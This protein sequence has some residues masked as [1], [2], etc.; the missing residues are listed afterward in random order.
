MFGTR[1][2]LRYVLRTLRR[3][4]GFTVVAVA[5]L[6]I[7]IGANAS[8][9]GVVRT[10]LL[11]PLPVEQPGQLKL[12][13]WQRDGDFSI[14]QSGST[15]YTDPATGASLRSNFSYPIYRA[16]ADAKAP[17]VELFAFAFV[18]GVSVA[19]G[20]QPAIAAGGAL[21]DG[22]YF[23][24]LRP[25]MEVGRALGP[26]DDGVDA[27]LVAV[28][29]HALW[30]R[31]F[32]G[33]GDVI[34]RSIRVN[35]AT[36]EVVGVTGT[37]FKGLSMGGFFPQTEITL[38]LSA[39]PRVHPRLWSDGSAF[40][41]DDL[42]WLRLMARVPTEEGET[43]AARRFATAM[44]SVPSPLIGTDGHLPELQLLDGSHGAQPLSPDTARLLYFLLGVVGIVL[45][46]ACLN[47]SSLMLARG[48]VRQRE[49]AVR[50][51]LG[52]GRARLVRQMLLE[53][54]VL[55]GLGTAAGLALAVVGRDFLRAL[56]TGSLGAGALGS[57][58]MEVSLDAPVLGLSVALATV[59]TL[60]FGLLPALRLSRVDPAE[61][62]SQR[63][64]G[65]NAPRLRT[66]RVLMALQLAVSVPL[67]VGALL[68]LRTASN[69][70]A[71]ELGFDPTQV[72][73]FQVNP[74]YTDLT[75]EE[76]PR[77]YQE[78]LAR[79]DALPGVRH[80]TLLENAPL[81]GIVSNSVFEVDGRRVS[82]YFNGI[83]PGFVETMGTRLLA[84][85]MPGLQD[86]PDDEPVAVVN[87]TAVR[88]VFQGESP[89][90]RTLR[91]GS[92]EIRIVGVVNDMPYRNQRSPV[93]ATMYP[94]A[95]QRSAWGGYHVFFRS[96]VPLASLETSL[97][98]VVTR[99]HR[100]IPVPR[101][102][103][104]TDIIAQTGAKERVFMQLLT[105]FGGFALLLAS[106]GLHGVTSYSVSRRTSEIGLRVAVGAQPGQ[107]A[108]LVLRQVVGLAL[109]GLLIGVPVALAAGPVVASLL[110]GVAPG[111]PT[112]VALA[113][114]VMFA[115]A[116]VSGLLPAL[117]AARV[118]PLVALGSE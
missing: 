4:P 69:L 17:D 48:V 114:L 49:I 113:A 109:V 87:E 26:D 97:R 100:D 50:R 116:V 57:L 80:A 5:S 29:S 92:R 62:L 89:V 63:G 101:I 55:A 10:L 15:G 25:R 9:F 75:P 40:L 45:L 60:A 72:A 7:G 110:F 68:F 41:A 78:L 81:S 53:A 22:S 106:I 36:V 74:A 46:I 6:A 30:M 61:W 99:V 85:R 76:Y 77:L 64:S 35:G 39:Q 86:G 98:E 54:I 95:F 108:G 105:L 104:Q 28:L 34:G 79:V 88:E 84:G 103:A 52:G 14:S 91:V 1:S 70:G 56:L 115:V 38:P 94:S 102:R 19:V 82:L 21:V 23:G 33:D 2:D 47:L 117:K 20:D 71:V 118:D 3:A 31:A 96:D 43:G 32:G 73:S 12:L 18:N 51:A 11:T 24:A 59:T 107:I 42:F 16:L 58:D 90:G 44:R 83:G 93:P 37:G 112:S 65:G 8:M 111:D 27:P 13:A 67:V 66:G